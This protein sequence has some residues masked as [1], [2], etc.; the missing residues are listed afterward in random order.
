LT[1]TTQK[2]VLPVVLPYGTRV[3]AQEIVRAVNE[4][5]KRETV[6]A[7]EENGFLIFRDVGDLGTSSTIRI[8]GSAGAVLGFSGQ[9]KARGRTVYPS[10]GL[11]EQSVQGAYF[12]GPGVIKSRYPKFNAPIRGN[13][14]FKVTYTTYQ[15]FCLRCQSYGIENDY[16]IGVNGNYLE[17]RDDDKLNQDS[18]KILLTIRGSNPY[19]PEYGSNL[20]TRIGI[21]AVGAGVTTITE[22]VTRAL[23]TLQRIQQIAGRY[24]D[25]SPKETLLSIQSVATTP[26]PTDPTVFEVRVVA[27]NA[28]AEPIVLRTVYAAP[29]SVALVG[30]NGQS[31]GLTERGL[32]RNLTS[33]QGLT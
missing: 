31:L 24:L 18:L 14:V 9:V 11:A 10:W 33:I 32:S 21:K 13:P 19:F 1:I 17:V 30:T 29:S 5:S 2:T 20:L 26:S 3:P 7:S 8:S 25:L 16:R 22:D 23:T 28:S 15:Q 27:S 12:V 4:A 6:I